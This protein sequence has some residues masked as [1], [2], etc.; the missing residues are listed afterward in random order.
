MDNTP[1]LI[2][3]TSLWIS[4]LDVRKVKLLLWLTWGHHIHSVINASD[5]GVAKDQIHIYI[6]ILCILWGMLG[7]VVG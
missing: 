2:S 3:S 5:I 7:A 4:L 1:S 6:I